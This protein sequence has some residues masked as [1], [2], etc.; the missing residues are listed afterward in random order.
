MDGVGAPTHGADAQQIAHP[1]QHQPAW[2]SALLIGTKRIPG[3]LIAS[4]IASASF[5]SFFALRNEE[6][7]THTFSPSSGRPHSIGFSG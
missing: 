1:Q 6:L 5:A 7:I 2:R 4:Q 3:R